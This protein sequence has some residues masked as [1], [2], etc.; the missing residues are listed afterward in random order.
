[1]K[2]QYVILDIAYNHKFR[3]PLE[4]LNL[5]SSLER[6]EEIDCGAAYKIKADESP[7]EMKIVPEE[8]FSKEAEEKHYKDQMEMYQRW[9]NEEQAKT[10]E[11]KKKLEGGTDA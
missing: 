11:L 4:D 6:I 1:M 8:M 3:I 9:W 7:L 10:A 5:V 2:K